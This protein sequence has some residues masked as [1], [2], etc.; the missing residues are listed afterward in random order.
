M[1]LHLLLTYRKIYE[2]WTTFS[3]LSRF[4]FLRFSR[5]S[6]SHSFGA[7]T[8]FVRIK[9][10]IVSAFTMN[11]KIPV[12]KSYLGNIAKLRF[13]GPSEAEG[14]QHLHIFILLL[15]FSYTNFGS[16]KVLVHLGTTRVDGINW[17]M[18]LLQYGFTKTDNL[19]NTNP[20]L[21]PYRVLLIL[22]EI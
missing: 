13:W 19:R 14:P 5:S 8:T 22:H 4:P 12:H 15:L 7:T 18:C 2:D 20:V 10:L 9:L 17:V 3:F 21:E 6:L 16:Y 11:P 1:P